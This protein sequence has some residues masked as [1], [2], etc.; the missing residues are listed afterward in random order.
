MLVG[1]NEEVLVGGM[2]LNIS[3]AVGYCFWSDGSNVAVPV[4]VTEVP[5]GVRLLS[6]SAAVGNCF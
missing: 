6:I 2:L 3:A 1:S 4:G 5:L